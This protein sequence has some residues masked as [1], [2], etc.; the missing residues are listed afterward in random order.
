MRAL[1]GLHPSCQLCPRMNDGEGAL[2][3]AI[4]AAQ[5]GRR[6][7]ALALL[8]RLAPPLAAYQAMAALLSLACTLKHGGTRLHLAL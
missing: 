4:A 7:L 1:P 5:R 2:L 3:L 6:S 8:H